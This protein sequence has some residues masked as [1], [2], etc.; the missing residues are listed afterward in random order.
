MSVLILAAVG[1]VMAYNH[2]SLLREKLV[3]QVAY[4]QK[5]KIS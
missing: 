5:R 3:A 2:H 1:A 4:F